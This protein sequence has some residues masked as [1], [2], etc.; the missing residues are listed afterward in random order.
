MTANKRIWIA[1]AVS[2][3]V[4]ASAVALLLLNSPAPDGPLAPVAVGPPADAAPSETPEAPPARQPRP[5]PR[6]GEIRTH[7]DAGQPGV[8]QP[9]PRRAADDRPGEK[10]S[11]KPRGRKPRPKPKGPSAP[12]GRIL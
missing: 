11:P 7:G 2:T 5:R 3:A 9:S 1:G 6:D 4:V 12:P 8:R 10:M